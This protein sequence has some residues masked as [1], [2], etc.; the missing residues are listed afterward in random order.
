MNTHSVAVADDHILMRSALAGLVN[1]FSGY[2]VL[3]QAANGNEVID[4]MNAGK[5]PEVVILDINMPLKDGFETALWLK[6]NHPEVKVLALSM[7]EKDISIIRMIRNGVKGY[8]L[9]A[10]DP[11]EL[12]EALD[13]VIHK[14]FHYS[15]LLTGHLLH[16]IQKDDKKQHTAMLLTEREIQFLKYV[17]T[18]LTY[19]E[20]AQKMFVSPR[21][22]DGYRDAL[23]EKLNVETRV[24]LVI[25]AIKNGIVNIEAEY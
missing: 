22:V 14:G 21:T 4:Q 2:K 17:C 15:P 11:S 12:K 19:K 23:F 20:I 9:K 5:I 16:S 18:E 24:G 1:S 7:Y 13:A 25:Y 6:N 3:F 10:A 8:I